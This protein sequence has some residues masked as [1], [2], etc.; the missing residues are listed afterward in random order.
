[1]NL[2]LNG[3]V[4]SYTLLSQYDGKDTIT[5][6][7]GMDQKATKFESEI[8]SG[9]YFVNQNDILGSMHF[10]NAQA[11]GLAYAGSYQVTVSLVGNQTIKTQA[12]YDSINDKL[13]FTLAGEGQQVCLSRVITIK[14]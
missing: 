9:C 11:L 13:M 6:R 4:N 3:T 2:D 12:A 1:M 5:V 14:I 10:L 7:V 8:G